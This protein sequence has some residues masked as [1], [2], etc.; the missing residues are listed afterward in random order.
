MEIHLSC[1]LQRKTVEP[2]SGQTSR[3]SYQ[4]LQSAQGIEGNVKLNHKDTGSESQPLENFTGQMSLFLPQKVS[5]QKERE[6][7]QETCKLQET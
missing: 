6:R 5:S 7:W 1:G 4:F 3:H 2:K